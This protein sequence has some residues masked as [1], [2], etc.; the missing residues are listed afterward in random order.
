MDK[1][2]SYKKSFI[3]L[4]VLLLLVVSSFSNIVYSKSSFSTITYSNSPVEV[5][6]EEI[7]GEDGF[8]AIDHFEEGVN[9][10]LVNCNTSFGNV[11]LDSTIGG[12]KSYNFINH[13]KNPEYKALYLTKLPF[14]NFQ[15]KFLP[16]EFLSRFGGQEF[17]ENIGY[18]KIAKEDGELY[19]LTPIKSDKKQVVFFRFKKGINSEIT[20]LAQYWVGKARSSNVLLEAFFYC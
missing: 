15:W 7:D 3:S 10:E 18:P 4:V 19:P 2:N 1:K 8:W 17:T 16:F 14:S 6:N 11:K 13:S 20:E 9:V 12:N 5:E